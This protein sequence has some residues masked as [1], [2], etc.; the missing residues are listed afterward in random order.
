MT[1]PPSR[2][3]ARGLAPVPLAQVPAP[4]L[5]A[6]ASSTP[7]ASGPRRAATSGASGSGASPTAR[8]GASSGV[9]SGASS[10]TRSGAASGVTSGARLAPTADGFATPGPAR[11]LPPRAS[12]SAA[13]ALPRAS[14]AHT[15]RAGAL[16]PVVL[17]RFDLAAALVDP[18]FEARSPAHIPVPPALVD[19]LERADRI[20]VIGHRRTDMDAVASASAYR[21]LEALGKQVSVCIDDDIPISIRHTL[22]ADIAHVSR[23][24]ALADGAWDL[25]VV[26]DTAVPDQLGPAAVALLSK[27]KE[28]AI[29][30]HHLASPTREQFALPPSTVLHTPW[31]DAEFPAA[32]LMTAALLARFEDRLAATTTPEQQRHFATLP[33]HGLLRDTHF[34]ALPGVDTSHY[35]YLKHMLHEGAQ[36]TL[37]AIR[38]TEYQVPSRVLAGVRRL[39]QTSAQVTP[40][41]SLST[42]SCPA[43]TFQALLTAP[44]GGPAADIDA[45]QLGFTLKDR[46]DRAA[47]SH[48]VALLVYG[49]GSGVVQVSVRSKVDT[50][51]PA[52][53]EHLG[54]QGEGAGG[55]GGGKKGVGAARVP[56]RSLDEVRALAEAW[57]AAH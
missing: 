53:A 49:T 51:A 23:A 8:S 30:D 43:P 22:G 25:A 24:A 45:D 29:V 35:H 33:L 39:P 56:G 4:A 42:L 17:P 32:G 20:L 47:Q 10:T 16:P 57:L 44:G 5:G 41:T 36:T 50:V 11:T 31:V 34:G 9:T 38:A 21:A 1:T 40:H 6:E 14:S 48:D 18:A 3:A 19:A 37:E 28:V 7:D 12:S 55:G 15:V 54:A 2:L 52:L 27:A 26:V 13:S 46:L